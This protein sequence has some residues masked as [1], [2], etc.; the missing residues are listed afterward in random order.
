MLFASLGNY[1]YSFFRATLINYKNRFVSNCQV[2][3][4]FS[5]V[6]ISEWEF[7]LLHIPTSIGIVSVLGFGYSDECVVI[8]PCFA[9]LQ[10]IW[11]AYFHL[12]ICL[13]FFLFSDV[14]V[15]ALCLLF[16]SIA[17]F[18]SEFKTL[19]HILN[20]CLLQNLSSANI[21]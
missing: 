1:D 2:V 21:S 12:L 6:A 3:V 10:D 8:C 5:T 18:P 7:W 13:L 4:V 20:N 17:W 9:L 16:N 19:F 14:S 11:Y 15:K